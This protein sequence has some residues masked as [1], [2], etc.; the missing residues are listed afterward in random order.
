MH[1]LRLSLTRWQ[2]YR[3]GDDLLRGSLAQL[4]Q[5]IAGEFG[6]Q[7]RVVHGDNHYYC[8]LN[9]QFHVVVPLDLREICILNVP[10]VLYDVRFAFQ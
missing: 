1:E 5:F 7:V 8:P 4:T 9:P 2:R 3:L 10:Q 6:R